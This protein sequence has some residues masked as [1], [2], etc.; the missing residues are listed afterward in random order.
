MTT[1]QIKTLNGYNPHEL[2]EVVDIIK[3][4]FSQAHLA[5]SVSTN[6]VDGPRSISR[7]KS[8]EWGGQNYDRDFTLVIDEP[9]E[10]GGTNLGPNPQEVLLAAF[11]SCV[12][13]TFTEFC[14]VEGIRLDRVTIDSRGILDL[15]GFFD[16]DANISP[17]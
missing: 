10:I 4:D 16:L 8:M 17:G 3:A 13:A 1:Q 5:F 12:L 7:V 15:R 14:T 9:E 6:W 2:A 11:N